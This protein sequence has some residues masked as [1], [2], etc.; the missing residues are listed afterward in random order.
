MKRVS[1]VLKIKGYDKVRKIIDELQ[2]QGSI[3]RKE[4]ELKCEKTAATTRRY[5]KFLVET[6]YVIQEGRTNSIIYKNIL[7]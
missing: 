2:D 4:A 5:I 1:E 3:T 6:G 7:Y